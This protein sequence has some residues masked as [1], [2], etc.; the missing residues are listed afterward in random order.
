MIDF[1]A[2][3]VS[4]RSAGGV[5]LNDDIADYLEEMYFSHRVVLRS[6]HLPDGQERLAYS[7]DEMLTVVALPN[8]SIF[9]IGCNGRYRGRCNGHL[10][11][12]Q[13]MGDVIEVTGRQR[14][15]NG[16]LVT[17]DD[18]GFSFVL[19]HPYDEMAD[20]IGDIP[21][22]LVLEELYVADFSAWNP[23]QQA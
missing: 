14:I 15:F 16:C 6:Y 13:T 8:G 3:I 7:L 19:P 5:A 10:Y 17:N 22:D 9:S 12:G 21:L 4:G 1:C 18:F 11:P 23:N 20:S 2:D